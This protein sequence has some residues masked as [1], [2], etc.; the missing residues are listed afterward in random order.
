M[1]LNYLVVTFAD[2]IY[3]KSIICLHPRQSNELIFWILHP[4][5]FYLRLFL[6]DENFIFGSRIIYCNKRVFDYDIHVV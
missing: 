5:V 6:L 1:T 3:I 2:M 4:H